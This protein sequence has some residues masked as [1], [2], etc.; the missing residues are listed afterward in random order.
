MVLPNVRFI[1][2][3]VHEDRVREYFIHTTGFPKRDANTSKFRNTTNLLIDGRECKVIE[4]STFNIFATGVFYGKPC[5]YILHLLI[6]W[7][8]SFRHY[9]CLPTLTDS[10]DL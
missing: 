2:K 9:S 3:R 4:I 5:T 7:L 10:I 6:C 8:T 1:T